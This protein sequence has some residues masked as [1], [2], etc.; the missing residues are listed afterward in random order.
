M[1]A[2][3]NSQAST[4]SAFILL[5]FI[6]NF[7]LFPMRRRRQEIGCCA[8]DT[9]L[10]ETRHL[11]TKRGARQDCRQG[12]NTKTLGNIDQTAK[13]QHNWKVLWQYSLPWSGNSYPLG[14]RNH[15]LPIPQSPGEKTANNLHAGSAPS[16]L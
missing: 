6:D 1:D 5:I 11:P 4:T 15:F 7:I 14:I 9:A 2:H 12:K 10:L 13:F 16:S 8:K 3:S